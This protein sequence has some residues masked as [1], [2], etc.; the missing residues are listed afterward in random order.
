MTEHFLA[1]P[2]G[3]PKRTGHT[4]FGPPEAFSRMRHS[5][6]IL[7]LLALG[8][9]VAAQSQP[10]QII[11]LRHAEKPDDDLSDHLSSRGGDRARALVGMFT[12]SPALTAHGRPAVL[13]I[14]R[15]TRDRT[16]LRPYQTL[17]P[18]AQE[19]RLSIHA[20]YPAKD[21]KELAQL[22]RKS[23]DLNGKVVVICW[24]HDYL[25]EL[26]QAFGVKP[27][28]TKWKN[29]QFDRVWSITFKDGKARLEDIPQL[30]LSGDSK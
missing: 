22:I 15:Q 2:F 8:F 30:L 16:S 24:V 12:N 26:A 4:R 28:Q 23:P 9:G 7:L 3:L 10:A 19:L 17:Q 13:Y 21:Y 1:G 20:P 5:L 6:I 18:L 14:P 27:K 25:P 29:S 11:L